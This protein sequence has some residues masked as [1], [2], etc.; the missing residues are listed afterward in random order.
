M[1]TVLLSVPV[2][3]ASTDETVYETQG[4]DK[5][6]IAFRNSTGNPTPYLPTWEN[7]NSASLPGDGR[8]NTTITGQLT[9]TELVVEDTGNYTNTPTISMEQIDPSDTLWNFLC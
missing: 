9:I 8:F 2:G 5:S 4:I 1:L 6:L 7:L 3:A